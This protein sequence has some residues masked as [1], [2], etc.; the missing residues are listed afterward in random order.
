[1]FVVSLGRSRTPKWESWII[2]ARYEASIG[3]RGKAAEDVHDGREY[4][5]RELQKLGRQPGRA[6][7]S[8]LFWESA[9][10]KRR[11]A[12]IRIEKPRQCRS[13]KHNITIS[14]DS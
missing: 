6:S 7:T 11:L 1:M 14:I 8:A 10:M 13:P 4:A 3:R 9:I 12:I 5:E 2:T